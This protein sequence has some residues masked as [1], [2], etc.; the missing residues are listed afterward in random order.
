MAS[1]HDPQPLR[2]L[3]CGG[4]DDWIG[5][6]WPARDVCPGCGPLVL[7]SASNP[8]PIITENPLPHRGGYSGEEQ[9]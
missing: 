4:G 9:E 8:S 1:K 3:V 7:K 5:W 2:C 6:I